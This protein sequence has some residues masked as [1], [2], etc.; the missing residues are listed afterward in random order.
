MG[1]SSV[2]QAQNGGD[3][4]PAGSLR[5]FFENFLETTKKCFIALR[6][7]SSCF[8]VLRRAPSCSIVL[9]RAPLCSIVLHRA[10]IFFIVR[11]HAAILRHRVFIVRR[12]AAVVHH[13][14]SCLL[15]K[16]VFSDVALLLLKSS[17]FLGSQRD[18]RRFSIRTWGWNNLASCCRKFQGRWRIITWAIK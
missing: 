2:P 15:G 12:R 11:H 16:H 4:A 1:F 7:A 6:R 10:L 8:I 14:A 9:H 17:E 5:R 13:R 3:W 18:L